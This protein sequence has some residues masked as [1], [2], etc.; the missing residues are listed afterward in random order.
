MLYNQRNCWKVYALTV[1]INGRVIFCR[2]SNEQVQKHQSKSGGSTI[3]EPRGLKSWGGGRAPR[4]NRSLRLYANGMGGKEAG[5]GSYNFIHPPTP[6]K[7]LIRYIGLLLINAGLLRRVGPV[8]AL[9]GDRARYGP[10]TSRKLEV[11]R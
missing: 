7:N 9:R 8:D 5:I 4:P 10:K 1:Y 3:G 6:K 11:L 2:Y